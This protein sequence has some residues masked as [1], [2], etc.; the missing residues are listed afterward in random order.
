MNLLDSG[1]RRNDES[2]LSLEV[3]AYS[4]TF[5]L[6]NRPPGRVRGTTYAGHFDGG[7]RNCLGWA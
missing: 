1:L 4:I 2:V 5:H 3:L 6:F 7:Q